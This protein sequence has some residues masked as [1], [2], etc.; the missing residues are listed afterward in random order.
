VRDFRSSVYEAL[1]DVAAVGRA[2][3]A[4]RDGKW[5]V[6]V[7]QPQTTPVQ[8][9][10]PRNSWD[11][12]TEWVFVDLPH[13]WRVRF[14]NEEAG[15]KQDERIVYRDGFSA[16]N[17]TKFE[18]MEFPGVTD[19]D[20]IWKHGRFHIAQG[21]RRSTRYS[22]YADFEHLA[23][24]RG[25]RVQLTHDVIAVGLVSGRI[26][27]LTTNGSGHV[28]SVTLDETMT[29]EASKS[30]GLAIRTPAGVQVPQIVTTPGS[31]N[32]ATFLAPI[33]TSLPAVG[34]LCSFG[35]LGEETLPALILSIEPGRDLSARI[36]CVD[37]AEDV[38]SADTGPI[39]EHRTVIGTASGINVPAIISIRSDEPVLRELPN[40]TL[41]PQIVVSLGLVSGRASWVDGIEAQY[42]VLGTQLWQSFVVQGRDV[43]DVL[44]PGVT[45]GEEYEIQLRYTRVGEL[46]ANN[47]GQ[48]VS[49][50]RSSA[51]T[52]VQLHTVVGMAN[53]PPAPSG[54]LVEDNFVRWVYALRPK[55]FKGF[56]VKTIVGTEADWTN[57]QDMTEENLVTDL[58]FDLNKLPPGQ[59]VVMIKA[60]DQAENE[61]EELTSV[62]LLIGDAP[63][64]NII[65]TTPRYP[66]WPGVLT[67][68]GI[69]AS[70]LR[71]QAFDNSSSYLPVADAVYL[72]EAA[73]LYLPSDFSEMTYET[74]FI[75]PSDARYGADKVLISMEAEG[76]TE[77]YYKLAT[78]GPYLPVGGDLYLPTGSDPYLP[79][80]FSGDYVTWPGSILIPET[81]DLI[82]MKV[83]IRGGLERGVVEQFSFIYDAADMEQNFNDL[84]VPDTGL[85]LPITGTWRKIHEVTYTLQDDGGTAVTVVTIDK[86]H[87]LG[88]LSETWDK[89]RV[90]VQGLIDAKVRG[91]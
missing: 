80:T 82:R 4:F 10:G 15:W 63:T 43:R 61:S 77:L 59:R 65:E 18:G 60:V 41:E 37:Y 81:Y 52:S 19:P 79:P 72:P 39:P 50:T 54:A 48:S 56:R 45:Q 55:D 27:S 91:Y 5:S 86:D 7:D 53:L 70:L 34:D 67:G 3:P 26:K 47:A 1:Q 23:C 76:L 2:S 78:S 66:D 51:W 6:V 40:G 58:R 83:R 75:F 14:V 90:P 20:G 11:F 71:L 62:T 38:Y 64:T 69:S 89:D 30:Y 88:P 31:T 42:R 87:I 16:A 8:L 74:D 49:G 22:F 68:C 73:A 57:A 44:I 33:T 28:V 21:I 85:R 35:E 36:T 32:S 9:F 46:T 12:T 17:A 24:T 13:G 84:V 29:M 25:D